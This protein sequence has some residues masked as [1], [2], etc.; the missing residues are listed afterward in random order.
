MQVETLKVFC[1]LVQ[2]GSFSQSAVRNFV[3]QSA[4][5]QQIRALEARFRTSLLVRQGRAAYPTEAGRILYEGAREILDRFERMDLDIRSMGEEVTGTVRIATIYSVGLYEMSAA[6]KT[7][8]KAHPKV[9]LH[10]EYSRA[11]RVYE[12]CQKGH[13]DIGIVTYPKPRKG[14]EVISLP[15]DKLILICSPQHPFA[16]RRRIDLAKLN[17]QNFVAFARDIPSRRALDQIFRA[18]RI[19]VRIVMELDNIETI[20]R[21]VEIGA[22]ISIVPLFSVQRE[23]QTGAL[24]QIHFM[25]HTFLRPLGVIVKRNRTLTAAAQKLIELL[26]RPQP[27]ERS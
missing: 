1:D 11:N 12:D 13:A 15:A 9:N 10:V 21:S 5:S 19:R 22:G 18:H 23:V 16:G 17:G 6:I 3:T 14:F 8:L 20:K 25:R 24:A 26:Q 27:T 7:F 2:S 4:V